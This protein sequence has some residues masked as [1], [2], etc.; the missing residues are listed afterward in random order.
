MSGVLGLAA[1]TIAA[2]VVH[3]LGFYW[4]YFYPGG[5][6]DP[7]HNTINAQMQNFYGAI[8]AFVADL[9]VMVIV[10]YLGRPKP[11]SYLAALVWGIPDPHAPDPR[12]APRPPWW[13]SPMMLGAGVLAIT[14]ALSVIFI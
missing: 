8:A 3:H 11:K 12:E 10:T 1:G 4:P 2:G 9:V 13:K 6:Y 5:H 7:T 14:I